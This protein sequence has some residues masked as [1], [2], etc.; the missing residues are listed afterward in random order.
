MTAQPPSNNT[1]LQHMHAE[2]EYA[3]SKLEFTPA[4]LLCLFLGM[5]GAHRFYLKRTGTAVTMLVITLV[6]LPLMF[7]FVGFATYLGVCVWAFVD[8]FLVSGIVQQE[9]AIRRAYVFAR[10]GLHAPQAPAMIAYPGYPAHPGYQ[11]PQPGYPALPP[12][13]G[14]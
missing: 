7:V 14:Y 6:S 11:Q 1:V 13:Q 12:G 3:A 2:S 10:Y 8:L 5:F 4:L 9:N